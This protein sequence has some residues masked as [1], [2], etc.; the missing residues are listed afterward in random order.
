MP[1]SISDIIKLHEAGF[2]DEDITRINTPA[3][4]T[5]A[6]TPAPIVVEVPE[7][8]SPT[9]QEILSGMLK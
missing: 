4:P 7:T 2:S 8:P 6:P 3:E 1:L 9:P 5:P